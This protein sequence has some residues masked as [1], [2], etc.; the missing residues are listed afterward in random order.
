ME[1]IPLDSPKTRKGFDKF[2]GRGE[3]ET[4]FTRLEVTGL[5]NSVYHVY[6]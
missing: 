6:I 1:D 5:F 4:D 3:N 2:N